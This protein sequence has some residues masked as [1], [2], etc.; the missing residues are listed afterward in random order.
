MS[1][2][3]MTECRLHGQQL[4]VTIRYH[5]FVDGF[6]YGALARV[7]GQ[8]YLEALG[9][10]FEI[11]DASVNTAMGEIAYTFDLVRV[12]AIDAMRRAVS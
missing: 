4:D 9:K 7:K 8:E 10:M 5:M 3:I 11:G 1:H 2:V 6:A 12:T